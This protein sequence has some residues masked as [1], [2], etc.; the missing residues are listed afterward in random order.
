MKLFRTLGLQALGIPALLWGLCLSP[1][2]GQW[3][4]Y[5]TA[6][7]PR[8]KDGKP[9]LTAACPR[10]AD[11]KP[12]LSGLWMMQPNRNATP[13]FPGCEPT[14]QE[15]GNI[16]FTLK[17]GLPYQPWAADLVK[18][19]RAEERLHDPLSY[20]L[21]PGPVRLHTWSTPRKIIQTPGLLVILNELNASYRQIFTDARPLP[22]DPNP[23]WNGYS[24]AKWEGDTL[25]VQTTGFRDGLWLDSLGNP[26]TDAGKLAERFRRVNFGHMQIELTVDDPKAYTKPWTVT[27]NHTIKLDTDLLDFIC[28]ENEKDTRHLLVQ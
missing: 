16:G 9:D 27:L 10:T 24:S 15:F 7:V 13:N 23:S 25:V 4:S 28:S 26:L 11:G 17:D 19:R 5:P 22:V 21:P 3:L 14:A 1:L 20:C 12:D 18:K 6:G 2:A 8:T